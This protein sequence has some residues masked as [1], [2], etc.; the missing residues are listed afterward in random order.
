MP[1]I[2]GQSELEKGVQVIRTH[3]GINLPIIGT[4]ITARY[5]HLP[6]KGIAEHTARIPVQLMKD[7]EMSPKVC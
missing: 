2:G 4:P 6:F 5:P 1:I 7:F 3:F